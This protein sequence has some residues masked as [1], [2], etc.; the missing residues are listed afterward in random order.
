M[1]EQ[2]RDEKRAE[3]AID[4]KEVARRLHVSYS[5]AYR[6]VASGELKAFKVRNS[7]RTSAA[8][9]DEYVRRRLDEQAWQCAAGEAE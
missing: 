6:L 4:L 9:C 3:A 1:N 2:E 5:T 8:A 7:W